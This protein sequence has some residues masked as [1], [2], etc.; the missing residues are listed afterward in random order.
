MRASDLANLVLCTTKITAVAIHENGI[1]CDL[2]GRVISSLNPEIDFASVPTP[3]ELPIL[4][5][6]IRATS[7]LHS[8][9]IQQAFFDQGVTWAKP[10]EDDAVFF[11]P[12]A[13]Y[14]FCTNNT[15]TCTKNV[16]VF[17]N[18]DLPEYL[19]S[20]ELGFYPKPLS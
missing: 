15:L 20:A 10:C 7:L 6:R 13:V 4:K 11:A 16:N 1:I 19:Y 8:R 2:S 12:E 3:P 5:L 14:I 18:K 17:I 9:L